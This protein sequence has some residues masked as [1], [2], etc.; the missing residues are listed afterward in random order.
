MAATTADLSLSADPPER[1]STL[2]EMQRIALGKF[3]AGIERRALRIAEIELANRDDALDVLQ[4][5]MLAFA[6]AYAGHPEADWA[7][8][9]HRVLASRI[10]DFRRRDAVRRRFRVWFRAEPDAGAED[11]LA[12]VA[13]GAEP[14]PPGRLADGEAR[15][16]L[17]DAL[18][19][20]PPRQ[21]QAFLLR[22]WEGLDVA[23]TA[24]AMRCGE[25]SVKTHL[26]RAMAGLRRALEDHR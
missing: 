1:A 15:G 9:F 4:D 3:L 16:A 24:R 5:A 12:L 25:G 2:P 8:L 7:P 17:D 14:G 13:D 21:R 6:K 23:D 11:P 19:A 26:F 22:V 18:G 10:A 20:L